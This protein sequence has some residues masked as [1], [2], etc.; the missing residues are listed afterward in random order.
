MWPDLTAE[1]GC[2][3]I[4]LCFKIQLLFAR[5]DLASFP[6]LKRSLG[7]GLEQTSSQSHSQLVPFLLGGSGQA[8][9]LVSLVLTHL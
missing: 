5:T 7:M 8:T 3:I 2:I 1:F 6:H 4:R 9:R